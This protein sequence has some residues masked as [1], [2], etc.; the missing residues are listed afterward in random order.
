MLRSRR[1]QGTHSASVSSPPQSYKGV[2]KALN[3]HL[4][5]GTDSLI[6]SVMFTIVAIFPLSKFPD[7]A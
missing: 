3:W 6:F 7:Q 1:R 5:D 2:R 4:D